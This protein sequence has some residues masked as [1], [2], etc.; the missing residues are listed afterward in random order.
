MWQPTINPGVAGTVHT[1]SWRSPERTTTRSPATSG[2]TDT[3]GVGPGGAPATAASAASQAVCTA[4]S[5][6][7]ASCVSRP[8]LTTCRITVSPGTRSTTGGENRSSRATMTTSRGAPDVPGV[9]GGVRSASRSAHP[10]PSGEHDAAR[11]RPRRPA[12]P[13]DDG[14]TWS[15]AEVPNAAGVAPEALKVAVLLHRGLVLRVEVLLAD[16]P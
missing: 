7:I 11:V 5:P 12:Q 1:T 15:T 14:A 9:I 8:P 6:T 16:R 4:S 2:G 10:A 13:N 3:T